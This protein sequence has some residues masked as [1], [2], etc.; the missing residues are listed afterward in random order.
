M[1][2]KNGDYTYV[3]D[4]VKEGDVYYSLRQK[5]IA[6]G[7]NDD[8]FCIQ[9]KYMYIKDGGVCCSDTHRTDV[10]TNRL[11]TADWLATSATWKPVVGE[12]VIF[13]KLTC[14]VEAI[15]GDRAWVNVP[16]EVVGDV[17]LVVD[18]EHLTEVVKSPEEILFEDI[19][20]V[21]KTGAST[22]EV[23]AEGLIAAG[24]IKRGSK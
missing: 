13:N 19:K 7:F 14:K 11:S 16:N 1:K 21:A 6:Q 22:Y 23:I 15:V 8:I 9:P 20:A 12:P 10:Q 18:I 17:A 4:I 3:G 24:Y 5:A 2:L